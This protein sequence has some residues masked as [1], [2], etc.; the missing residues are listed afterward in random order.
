M[1]RPAIHPV[2][3]H[4]LVMCLLLLCAPVARCPA[5]TPHITLDELRQVRL[6]DVA[7]DS[8][9]SNSAGYGEVKGTIGAHILFELLLPNDWNQRFV[10]GGGGGFV[11]S[12][13]N[14]ALDSVK[15]GYATAGTD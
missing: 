4:R 14:G 9:S 15:K 13:Q 2:M 6:P 11:G 5:A 3:N 1:T 12:I 10:M 7:L 8:A